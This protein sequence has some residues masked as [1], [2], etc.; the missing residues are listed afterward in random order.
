MQALGAHDPL[1][2]LGG[3]LGVVDRLGEEADPGGVLPRRRQLMVDHVAQEAVGY[4]D[5]DPGAVAGE[6][7]GAQSS[8]VLEVA[9]RLDPEGHHIV[10]GFATDVA[11]EAD[12]A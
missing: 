4:L 3:L 12:A 10:G 7:I 2:L 11:H 1:H 5:Q 6:R 9:Q 8:P